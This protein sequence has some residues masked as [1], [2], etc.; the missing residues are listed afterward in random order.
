M[1]NKK[2]KTGKSIY[3]LQ[4]TNYKQYTIHKLQKKGIP[5]AK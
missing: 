4:T 5:D 2:R 3:N 1:K